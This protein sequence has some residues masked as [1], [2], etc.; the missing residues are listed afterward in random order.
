MV[1]AKAAIPPSTPNAN[2]IDAIQGRAAIGA[3]VDLGLRVALLTEAAYRSA[4]EGQPVSVT[5]SL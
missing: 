2:F 1:D 5:K 4:R 3:D